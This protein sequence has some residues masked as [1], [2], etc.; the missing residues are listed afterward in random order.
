MN[1]PGPIGSLCLLG[2]MLLGA[3]FV[4]G[5]TLPPGEYPPGPPPPPGQL[6]PA[7]QKLPENAPATTAAPANTNSDHAADYATDKNGFRIPIYVRNVLVPTTVLDPD[8]HGYVNGLK[9]GDFELLDNNS[10]QK[11]N[12]EFVQLPMSVVLVVQANSEIEPVLPALKKSGVLLQGLVTGQ[13]SDVAVI[14]FDHRIQK[15]QDFTTDPQKIDDAMQKLTAGS[16]SARLIDSVLEA[17]H[18]LTQHDAQGKRRRVIVLLSR[19]LDKGS[20]S[21]LEETARKMQFDNVI[22]YCV[23]IS[24]AYTG[25]M[26][27]QP[28]P[29]PAFGGIPPEAQPNIAGGTPRNETTN[30]QQNGYE[31]GFKALPPIFHGI[32]D[33]FKRTPAEAFSTFTGGRMY[34][35]VKQSGLEAA[36]SDIGADLNSQYLLSYSPTNGNEPGFH[37]IKVNIDR[38]GLVVR[39]RP[40]YWTGGGQY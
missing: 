26:D 38:P 8:G 36:I 22:V 30:I 34:G 29:R 16:G 25:F 5:Q 21:H 31:N 10:P 6:G 39:V 11:I 33:L 15:I 37:T 20:E 40:G 12:A 24:R 13:D 1:K 4:T 23:D 35:F 17:D 18:M 3:S 19:N 28:Y 27:K 7:P 9:P 32:H 2:T 14:G